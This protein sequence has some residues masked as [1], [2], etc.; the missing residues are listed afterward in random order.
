MPFAPF[1]L[2]QPSTTASGGL[3]TLR[4]FIPAAV[5]QMRKRQAA[6]RAAGAYLVN[7]LRCQCARPQA[8]EHAIAFTVTGHGFLLERLVRPLRRLQPP[9]CRAPKPA[10]RKSFPSVRA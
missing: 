4:V 6:G 5:R 3:W 2:V 1:V 7:F 8:E 10:R 9:M